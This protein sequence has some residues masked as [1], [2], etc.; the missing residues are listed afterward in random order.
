MRDFVIVYRQTR[1][2]KTKAETPAQALKNFEAGNGFH[3]AVIDEPHEQFESLHLHGD[4]LVEFEVEQGRTNWCEWEVT[5][6]D[7]RTGEESFSQA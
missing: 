2:F 7:T 4:H 5:E 3:G 6:R 1:E